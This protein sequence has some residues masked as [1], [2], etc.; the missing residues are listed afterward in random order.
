MSNHIIEFNVPGE[1][2]TARPRACIR[3]DKPGM[4]KDRHVVAYQRVVSTIA[5]NYMRGKAPIDAP[6]NVIITHVKPRPKSHTI[7]Q[8]AVPWATTKPDLDNIAK[9][10]LDAMNGIVFSDDSRVA[11]LSIQKVYRHS[12]EEYIE[13][14]VHDLSDINLE[15]SG[16]CR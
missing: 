5:R 13:V 7:A 1:P 2:R 16:G 10:I 15:I 11:L 3:G 14:S 4:H 12:Q 8:K 9:V 6:V